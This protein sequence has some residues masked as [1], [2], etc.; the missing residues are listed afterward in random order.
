MNKIAFIGVGNMGGPMALNLIKSGHDVCAFDLVSENL[1][2]IVD[3]GGRM[4]TSATD[5]INGAEVVITMLPA[6]E[7][8]RAVYSQEVLPNVSDKILLIDCS[9]IDVESSKLVHKQAADKGC[10]MVDAPVSGGVKK[11]ADGTLTFMVGGSDASFEAAQPYLNAMG[12]NIFNCGGDCAG[13]AVKMCNNMMLGI[14]MASMAEAFVLGE[15]LGVD[16]QK[17]FDVVTVSTGQCWSLTNYCPVPGLVPS[18]PSNNDFEG[19]FGA[20]LMLKDM[21]LAIQA[22]KAV[23][24]KV[25]V[26]EMA[27]M[28]YRNF[29]EAGSGGKDFSGVIELIRE[30][31]MASAKTGQIKPGF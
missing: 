1:D 30:R 17:L 21:N 19:G 22:A 10:R 5:A 16:P 14:Q 25:E 3:G 15:K 2:T 6:G 13:Q 18:A 4:A 20:A 8:V 23:G 24:G 27:A 7:H 26:T 11:A 9:T 28:L 29:C 31:S 12:A